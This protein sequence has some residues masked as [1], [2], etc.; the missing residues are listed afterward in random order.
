MIRGDSATRSGIDEVGQGALRALLQP[1]SIALI[2]AS[3]KENS[4]GRAMVG[5]ATIGGFGGA[6]Y[7]VNPRYGEISGMQCFGSLADLPAV[8][9]HVV[10]GVGNDRVEQ[11]LDEAIAHGARAAT[12]FASCVI[13]GDEGALKR[14]ITAKARAAGI[15]L[16]G[17]NCMGFYNNEI[18]LRVA[19]FP[20]YQPM[21]A[22]SIGLVAQSG[23]VFAAIAHN[24]QRLKLNL[25][26]SSG[27]E[28]VTGAADY[29]AWMSTSPGINVVGMFLESIRAPEEFRAALELAATRDLPVV[30]L[31]IGRTS[32]SAEMALSHTGAIV[33]DDAACQAMFRRYGVIQVDDEDELAATLCVFQQRKRPGKGGLVAIHDS[34]G[35]RELAVDIADGVGLHYPRLSGETIGDIA[36]IIDPEL[37][38]ANPL[39]VWSSGRDF[40]SAA[41]LSLRTMLDDDNAAIGAMFCNIRDGYYV[42]E[43]YV[44]ALIEVSQASDKPVVLVTNYTMVRHDKLVVK[45]TAHGIPVVD[46]TRVGL[47]AIKALLAFRDRPDLR[48]PARPVGCPE[49]ETVRLWQEKLSDGAPLLEH[50]A[51]SLLSA[52]GIPTA[53]RFRLDHE[54]Q[55]DDVCRVLDFPVVLKTAAPGI[56]H[57]SD[58]GGVLLN[59]A[60]PQALRSAYRDISSRLGSQTIVA[61]MVSK[62]VELAL[63][64]S[65]DP[66]WGPLLVV[67]AGGVLMELLEDKAAAI[68]PLSVEHAR[69]MVASLKCHP[70]LD[71]YRGSPG[72]DQQG[73]VD[74]LVR[75]SWLADDL[76]GVL[77]EIDVNPLIATPG[78]VRAVDAVIIPVPA[79]DASKV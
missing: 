11:A 39:D 45:L 20:A 50:D 47:K 63:G 10:I 52:Y 19:G 36:R 68:G 65:V 66:Q 9:E 40:Q 44:D 62:G 27:A 30:I 33:G 42:S 35:E 67:S 31:K 18:G 3:E 4:V 29:L 24:D 23:S 55:I 6:V 46:G 73:V 51:L 16:C 1:R 34:G 2:G 75:L 26:I 54:N 22:G 76:R 5:M 64:V 78:G 71:G 53:S 12:V 72:V 8:V 17:G 74:A 32:A 25:A 79:P 15:A 41:A 60:D 38:P 56:L 21:V 37:T 13:P 58:V 28:L 14:R 49:M 43:G 57:K 77:S 59:I 70:I 48:T 61:E 69:K 7:P